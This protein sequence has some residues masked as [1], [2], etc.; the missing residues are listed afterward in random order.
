MKK[1]LLPL[2][3]LTL[4]LLFTSCDNGINGLL[5]LFTGDAT[6]VI[7]G[8]SEDKYTSSI[9]MYNDEDNPSYAIGLATAMDVTEL[10][11]ISGVKDLEFPFLTYRLT[12][13]NLSANTRLEVDNTLTNEDLVDFDYR[14]LL[15]GKFAENQVVGIAKTPTLFYVMKSGSITITKVKDTK[16]EGNYS[17]DA[18]VIDLEA[19][20]MLSEQLVPINGSF[21][22]KVIP[23]MDW[24][25]QLQE[26]EVL[27]EE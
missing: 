11:H 5:E 17:G 7:N 27:A 12:H 22:S 21:S 26:E 8:G 2:V 23:M 20:P 10:M 4:A 19:E 24:L 9:I 1:T 13:N 25:L 14:S 3:L 18:Y 16:V 15:S 6:S